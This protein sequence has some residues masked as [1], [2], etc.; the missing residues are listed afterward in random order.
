MYAFQKKRQTAGHIRQIGLMS[1]PNMMTNSELI[2]WLK[3]NSSG[4]YRPAREAADRMQRMDKALRDML[5]C[6]FTEDNC[7]DLS[8]ASRRVRSAARKALTPCTDE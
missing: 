5:H 7:A 4:V 2:D 6:E 1:E 3:E 8:I